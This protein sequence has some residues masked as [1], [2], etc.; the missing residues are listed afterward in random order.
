MAAIHQDL[1]PG[2]KSTVRYVAVKLQALEEIKGT[3][4]HMLDNVNTVLLALRR[5]YNQNTY[6]KAEE[7]RRKRRMK[8]QKRK[9]K[10]K[11]RK[12]L[13]RQAKEVCK[14]L[15]GNGEIDITKK[16]SI[17][18]IESNNLNREALHT[19]LRKRFH[20]EPLKQ[21]IE[22]G[23]ISDCVIIEIRQAIERLEAGR[24]ASRK[25]EDNQPKLFIWAVHA[26][27]AKNLSVTQTVSL[28]QPHLQIMIRIVRL[29]NI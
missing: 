8:E 1:V 10:T 9:N 5:R 24:T 15:T 21:L 4:F 29:H 14:L 28:H 2:G 7:V 12:V 16:A 3:L 19:K 22:Q 6:T 27:I 25:K 11:K 17:P 26:L 18:V 20:L 13:S 23:Y